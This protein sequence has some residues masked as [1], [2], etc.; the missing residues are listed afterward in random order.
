MVKDIGHSRFERGI[1]IESLSGSLQRILKLHPK[2][3]SLHYPFFFPYGEDGF[4]VDI[5]LAYQGYQP[6]K[7]HQMVMMRAYYAYLIHKR[8]KGESTLIKGGRLYQ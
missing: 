2:F 5:A 8:E 3:M 1:I 6:P 7:K 4:H